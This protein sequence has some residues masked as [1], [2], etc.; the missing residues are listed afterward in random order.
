[1]RMLCGVFTGVTQMMVCVTAVRRVVL[2]VRG[3]PIT[4]WA[5]KKTTCVSNTPV[6]KTVPPNTLLK[7]EC[8][9]AV[10]SAVPNVII[11]AHAVV[12]NSA[13]YIHQYT[14]SV[15]IVFRFSDFVVMLCLSECLEYYFLHEGKCHDDCPEGYFTNV[16]QKRCEPCHTD[17]TSCDG[18]DP[19]DCI[20]CKGSRALRY[21]GKCLNNCPSYTY[22]DETE[23]RGVFMCSYNI[24]NTVMCIYV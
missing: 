1:M 22:L 3:K 6:C 23:C 8:V 19:D 4:V 18:P 7:M 16:Q 24:S 21:N 2:P 9:S 13:V 11:H 17:C 20:S 12:R 15:C 14:V 5:V 10:Q